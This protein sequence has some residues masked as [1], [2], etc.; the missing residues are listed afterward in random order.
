MLNSS[1]KLGAAVG[2]FSVFILM[3]GFGDLRVFGWDLTIA[4][5]IF[6]DLML[7]YSFLL[8]FLSC[9]IYT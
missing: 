7:V 9:E 5:G 4:N 6:S 8:L 3:P 1:G 2:S